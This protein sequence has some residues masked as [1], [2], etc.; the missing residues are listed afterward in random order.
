[1]QQ[2]H[3]QSIS[4]SRRVLAMM[5]MALA[6]APTVA[7][8]QDAGGSIGV[9]LTILPPVTTQAVQ[10]LAFGVERDG[11]ARL[12]TTTP[13][14]SS[15]SLIVMTTVASSASGF[16]PIAQAPSLVRTTRRPEAPESLAS[17]TDSPAPRLRYE[18]DL[19]RPQDGPAPRD[20]SVRISYLVV[21]GT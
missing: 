1:M 10:L 11:T 21:A 4:T 15:T 6:T 17:S 12:E 14:E 9:S 13:M 19:G 3:S 16:V 8:A 20:A 2:A 7:R 5:L 18:V